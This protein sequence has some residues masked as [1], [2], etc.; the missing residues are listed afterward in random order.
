MKRRRSLECSTIVPVF[1]TLWLF[2]IDFKD[3]EIK[4]LFRVEKTGKFCTI[5]L[6]NSEQTPLSPIPSKI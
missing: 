5:C 1:F 6:Y 4:I 2:L 3:T